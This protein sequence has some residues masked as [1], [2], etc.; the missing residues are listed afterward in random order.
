MVIGCLNMSAIR[1]LKKDTVLTPL[2]FRDYTLSPVHF[3]L[4]FC[5]TK[6]LSSLIQKKYGPVISNSQML[7]K[8]AP[9]LMKQVFLTQSLNDPWF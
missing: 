6:D 9:H 2:Q 7:I 4:H 1:L 8:G 5:V 3:V